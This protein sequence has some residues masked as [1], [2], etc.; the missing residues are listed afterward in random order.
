[1]S[2]NYYKLYIDSVFELAETLV[3]KSE[4]SALKINESLKY[5]PWSNSFVEHD[6]TTWKYYLNLSGEYHASDEEIKVISLDTLQE[7]VFNKENLDIHKATAKAYQYNS[8][9]YREL[10]LRYP[11]QEILILG[12]LYPVDIQ[13][14]IDARDFSVLSY[15]KHLVEDNEISLI[16][17]IDQWLENFDIRWNNKQFTLTDELYGA[18]ILGVLYL[19]LVP[20]IINLRLRACKTSE[21]HSFHVREYLASHGM[22]DVYLSKMTKKQALFFYRNILYIERNAGKQD[23]FYWLIDKVMTDRNLPISEYGAQ[24]LTTPMPASFTPDT[25]FK[26]KLINESQSHNAEVGALFNTETILKKE[27]KIALG[28][29]E[30]SEQNL[31]NIQSLFENSLSSN[32]TTKVL[33]SSMYDYNDA[34]PYTLFSVFLNQWITFTNTNRFKTGYIRVKNP[35]TSQEII[36]NTKDSY[37]YYLY[38]FAKSAKVTLENIPPVFAMRVRREPTP[39][40]DDLL[41]VVDTDKVTVQDAEF[42]INL[43]KGIG[44]VETLEEFRK[45]CREIHTSAIEQMYYVYRK[46]DLSVRG[47]TYNM[48]NRL[49]E[50]VWYTAPYGGQNYIEWLRSKNLDHEN[51]TIDEWEKLYKDIYFQVTGLD[52][53]STENTSSIQK[54]MVAL[55]TQL[56]S[57]SIQIISDINSRAIHTPNFNT[58]RIEHVK[59]ASRIYNEI[60]LGI[61]SIFKFRSRSRHSEF[62]ELDYLLKDF[63]II[64]NPVDGGFIDIPIDIVPDKSEPRDFGVLDLGILR[65][66]QDNLPLPV[67]AE[68]LGDYPNYRAYYLMNPAEKAA[69][70]NVYCDCMKAF[71]A[72]TKADIKDL[73]IFNGIPGLEYQQIHKNYLNL[74]E[75]YYL[76]DTTYNFTIK[77]SFVELDCFNNNFDPEWLNNFKLN[78][79]SEK[80][81]NFTIFD[82]VPEENNLLNFSYTGGWEHLSVFSPAKKGDEETDLDMFKY[83][84]GV[85]TNMPLEVNIIQ[86]NIPLF[87]SAIGKLDKGLSFIYSKKD[88]DG[89]KIHKSSHILNDLFH[90]TYYKVDFNSFQSLI[91]V[92]TLPDMELKNVD[93]ATLNSFKDMH[94]EFKADMFETTSGDYTLEKLFSNTVG[95]TEVFDV[96]FLDDVE[97][98]DQD[99]KHLDLT[100]STLADLKVPQ[101]VKTLAAFKTVYTSTETRVFELFSEERDRD[102]AVFNLL[103]EEF[104][105]E[106]PDMSFDPDDGIVWSV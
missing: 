33:E 26:K 17:N 61:F 97:I 5:S 40:V 8:R 75:Y 57:Y 86:S 49:Y 76:P 67:T 71:R 65:L 31:K 106:L 19:Q 45:A 81:D 50:D 90:S 32:L 51:F 88:M 14:A 15:P 62:I 52:S 84:N 82:E 91:R 93:A 64:N 72:P 21:A 101:A 24:H 6:K 3:I 27:E 44:P 29:K 10:V 58:V 25:V 83:H 69:I 39:D 20:L 12:I 48:T 85:L 53:S 1:M 95:T 77:G 23:T 80:L 41:S 96:R 78:K 89:L 63:T 11:E 56:S 94:H 100:D 28:N 60:L 104:Y 30:Y 16:K 103:T 46:E 38:A 9:Y 70:K 34:L 99:F 102:S 7:I 42:Q 22:L 87:Q 36:L 54:A 55:L 2:Q 66:N 68:N 47:M 98:I 79:G 13:T 92:N 43:Q 74:F 37:L 105:K 73:I 4:Y 35:R 59:G 18:T